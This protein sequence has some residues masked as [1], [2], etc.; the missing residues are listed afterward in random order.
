MTPVF[1]PT[2]LYAAPLVQ[3]FISFSLAELTGSISLPTIK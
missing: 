3:Q 2:W 1:V